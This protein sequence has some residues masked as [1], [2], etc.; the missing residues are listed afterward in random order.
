MDTVA[1]MSAIRHPE[2]QL[3]V[4]VDVGG[5][6]LRLIALHGSRQITRVTRPRNGP[7]DLG[8]FL[9]ALW[10]RHRWRG[11]VGGLVV[12]S[13]GV[14]TGRE[15]SA[16]ARRLRSLATRVRVLSDAQVA[17]LGALG[18]RP[19]LLL[20]SGTGSIVVGRD[21]AGRWARAGGFG[22]LLGDEGSAFWLGREWL[23]ATTGGEDF[24]AAR[25]FMRAPDAVSRIASLAPRVLARARRGDGRARAIVRAGQTALA[26]Q[27]LD[28][29]R[30]L[31]LRGPLEVS[32][33]GSVLADRWFRAGV[34]RALAR[35]GVRAHWRAPA[36]APVIA[37]A[38][39][40]E[41]LRTQPGRASLRPP[42]RVAASRHPLRTQPRRASLRPPT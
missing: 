24:H 29:S 17:L 10:R 25:R 19:G 1:T 12:A 20:L 34:G 11:R 28:V 15:R 35:V 32:W 40:A 7:P 18:E 5:T 27:A 33:A 3:A 41:R 42:T 31:G 38:Q 4:G 13:R 23:R 14:W 22:P 30:R 2:R 39:L 9:R 37:A 21:A 36:A 16:M 26:R 6:W 8:K